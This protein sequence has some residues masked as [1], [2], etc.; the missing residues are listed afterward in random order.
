MYRLQAEFG[1]QLDFINLNIDV[2][3]TRPTRE[4]FGIVQRSNYVLIDAA[5]NE[6]QRWFGPLNESVVTQF[7]RDY[8]ASLS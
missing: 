8:L 6:V 7:L 3:D 2:E 1:D 4:R 5:G